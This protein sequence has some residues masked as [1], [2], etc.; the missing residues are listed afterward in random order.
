[1][2]KDRETHKPLSWHPRLANIYIERELFF[3]R[4]EIL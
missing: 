3:L 2:H 1:M 4:T